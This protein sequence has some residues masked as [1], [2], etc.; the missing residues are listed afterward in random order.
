ME[1]TQLMDLLDDALEGFLFLLRYVA[2]NIVRYVTESCRDE[3]D[4]ELMQML[5][6]FLKYSRPFLCQDVIPREVGNA[7]EPTEVSNAMEPTEVS[8]GMEPTEDMS[9][10]S[11]IAEMGR[12]CSSESQQVLSEFV[13]IEE[14][15]GFAGAQ[16]LHFSMEPT[17]LTPL[18]ASPASAL[19]DATS[20]A[21]EDDLIKASDVEAET[22]LYTEDDSTDI[23]GNRALRAKTGGWKACRFILA[24]ECCERLAFFGIGINLVT[25]LTT[26]LKQGNVAAAK[27]VNNWAG[28]CYITPFVGAFIADGYWGRYWTI[29]FFS[30]I[31]FSGMILLTLTAAIPALRPSSCSSCTATAGQLSVFY[32]ALYLIALGTGGI[33]PCVSSFGADQFDI[34]DATE[35]KKMSSF[36]NW[37]YFSINIGALIA[38]SVLVYIQ[39]NFSWVWGFGIPAAAM[40]MAG[41]SFVFGS[42]RYRHQKAG[43]NPW[44]RMFQVC[45]AAFRKWKEIIPTDSSKLHETEES[46]IPGS[47][48][49]EHTNALL[50]ADADASLELCRAWGYVRDQQSLVFFDLGARA[51]FITPQLAEKMGIKTV[52]MGPAYTASMAAPGHEVAVTPLI[53]KLRLHIQGYVGHKEFYIMPLEGCDVLLGMPRFY[54]HKAVLDSFNKTVS[55]EIRGTKIVLELKLKGESVPLVSASAVPD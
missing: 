11:A 41:C 8:N 17:S 14:E 26:M 53:G 15:F 20:V 10:D 21:L 1:D 32:L 39:D 28:T 45:V 16:E 48:K 19:E 40:G 52:E 38:S 50:S 29:A 9:V 55:L 6:E 31:H 42:P 54:N 5:D 37:F 49:F 30:L 13:Q 46:S 12:D 22:W 3:K 44:A 43:G 33:K 18:L 27:T 23:Y 4:S 35:R 47:R 24:N 51:N 25:Y 36:F 7:M 34:N 2:H